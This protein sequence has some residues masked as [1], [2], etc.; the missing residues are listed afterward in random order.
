MKTALFVAI[1]LVAVLIG[2]SITEAN[3]GYG[4]GLMLAEACLIFA[5]WAC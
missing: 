4:V 2:K 5:I 1:L 3:P